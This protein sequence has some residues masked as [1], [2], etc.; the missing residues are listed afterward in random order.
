M[1]AELL[2]SATTAIEN[3]HA[4]PAWYAIW[5]RSH[6]EQFVADQLSSVG[7]QIFCPQSL[8]WVTRGAVRRRVERPL[9]PGYVFVE[10]AMDKAS[11]VAILKARGVVKV[12]G[13][14]WDSLCTIPRHELE[15]VQRLVEMGVPIAR[16][17]HLQV[18]DRV[19][20]VSGPLAGIEGLFVRARKTRGLLLLSLSLLQRS[21]AVEVDGSQVEAA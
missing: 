5:T 3:P 18:G 21:I 2:S 14:R 13:D 6:C 11:H 7:F 16:H 15:A 10:H 20:I 12:L 1:N 4:E 8:T 9:F 17:P 19:R